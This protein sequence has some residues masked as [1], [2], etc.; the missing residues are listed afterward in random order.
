MAMNLK[1]PLKDL[2]NKINQERKTAG[3]LYSLNKSAC[4][5]KQM[6]RQEGNKAG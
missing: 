5:E 4:K 6:T 2:Q 1:T 3:N